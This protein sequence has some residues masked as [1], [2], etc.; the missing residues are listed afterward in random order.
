MKEAKK[1]KQRRS[2]VLELLDKSP[3]LGGEM[4]RAIGVAD[5]AFTHLV[6][7]MMADGEIC[8]VPFGKQQFRYF[9]G[10]IP[11]EPEPE[12]KP[13]VTYSGPVSVR[14]VPMFGAHGVRSTQSMR[15][16]LPAA[17]WEV[18]A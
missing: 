6:R 8:R 7:L 10:S 18:G 15:I 16:T 3:M 12:P 14:I 4:K 1:T 9:I 13:C 11:P 5:G 17:P 2:H